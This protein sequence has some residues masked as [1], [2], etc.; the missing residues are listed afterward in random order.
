MSVDYL[1]EIIKLVPPPESPIYPL[2]K[3]H[4]DESIPIDYQKIS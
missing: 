3:E 2:T 4:F 1:H